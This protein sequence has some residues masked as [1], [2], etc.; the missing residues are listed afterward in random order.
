MGNKTE[1]LKEVLEK[2]SGI[3][4]LN[5]FYSRDMQYWEDENNNIISISPACEKITGFTSDEFINIP[6][7]IEEIIFS[8]DLEIW[9]KRCK[10]VQDNHVKRVQFRINHKSGKIVWLEHESQKLYN[11]KGIF[12]GFRS[13][14]KDITRSKYTDEIIDSNSSVLFLWKNEEGYPVEF[15]SPN[16]EGIFGYTIK[17]FLSGKVCYNDII[18]PDCKERVNSEVEFNAK[19]KEENFNHEPYRI[20]TKDNRTIWVSDRTIVKMDSKNNITH[21]HGIVTDISKEKRAEEDL[22]KSEEIYRNVFTYSPLG[23]LHFDKYGIVTDCNDEFASII[24]TTRERLI[25]F[26]MLEQLTDLELKETVEKSLTNGSG[27]Y[28]NYYTSVISGKKT[29]AIGR[30]NAIYSDENEIIGGVGLIEDITDRTKHENLQKA[31]FDISETASKIISMEEL[32]KELHVIIQNLMPAENFYVAIHNSE[33]NIISFPYHV[34][35]HDQIP[36]PKILGNGLTEYILKTKKSQIITADIDRE[37]Q[38]KGEVALSGEFAQIWVGI[39]LEFEGN[40][41]GVLA[42]QD[43]KN[44]NAYSED[45]VKVLEF[46]STQIVKILDKKYADARLRDFVKELSEAKQELEIINEN[47]DRFFSIIAHD[48]RSP[49]NTLLGVT[50]TI[51]GDIDDMSVRE[52]KLIS[53]VIHV[54]SQNLFKLIENLLSWS[55]LQM[56]VFKVEP[57]EL[58]INNVAKSVLEILEITAKEKEITIVNNLEDLLIFADEECVK[59]VL[60]N[61]I[62]NAIKFTNRQGKIELSSNS[63]TKFVE[64]SVSDN[65]V[66]MKPAD[67]K[68]TF[69]I[70]KKASTSGTEDEVGTGLGLILCK[71][72]I[73]KNN[74]KIWVESKFGRGSQFHFTLPKK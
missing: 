61:L 30:F 47:K 74:G 33:T 23:I 71:D 12:I 45:D 52:V 16:V 63:T 36:E 50:E 9:E 42:L 29:P 35:Q 20:I 41:K 7:L 38:A 34:D 1:T 44:V 69:S 37:L 48:L 13:S 28:K 49:L 64:I 60:R 57:V 46:V 73:E 53:S 10:E 24:G 51:S 15:V 65:G 19:A 66:G 2:T 3:L 62:S 56:G 43:Y 54:S 21:F 70:H 72:L 5:N 39:Y 22:R 11:S 27:Y 40:Y 58:K 17:D 67:V 25:G 31:L 14:N 26:N 8:E 59:T 32:Y 6:K 55:S 4:G 18:H 68:K